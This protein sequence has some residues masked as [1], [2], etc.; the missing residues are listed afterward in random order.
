MYAFLLINVNIHEENTDLHWNCL[1]IPE[2]EQ[3]SIRQA[4]Q[5]RIEN[6]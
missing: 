1:I 6:L 4:Y 3:A 2:T 5:S